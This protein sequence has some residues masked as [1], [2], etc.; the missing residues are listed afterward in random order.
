MGFCSH[1]PGT[2]PVVLYWQDAIQTVRLKGKHD[3]LL[4][5]LTQTQ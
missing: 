1:A 3:E 4:I 5:L 2:R